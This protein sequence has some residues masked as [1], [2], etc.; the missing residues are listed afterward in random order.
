MREVIPPV[1]G[2]SVA[3]ALACRR[4]RIKSTPAVRVAA[5]NRLTRKARMGSSRARGFVGERSPSVYR[6][7]HASKSRI[8]GRRK[9]SPEAEFGDPACS[10]SPMRSSE[11]RGLTQEERRI[12]EFFPGSKG[13]E[14]GV[15][16]GGTPALRQD[17][18][19]SPPYPSV[20]AGTRNGSRAFLLSRS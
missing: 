19:N 3:P 1:T 9:D 10:C 13:L 17:S 6:T 7:N 11:N 18:G 8:P 4:S 15:M 12:P 14:G 20:P 16:A 5:P 2:D